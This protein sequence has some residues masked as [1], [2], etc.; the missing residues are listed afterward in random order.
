MFDLHHAQ[1]GEATSILCVS[2]SCIAIGKNHVF[3]ARMKHI[4]NHYHYVRI[5]L[6][7]IMWRISSLKACQL[8]FLLVTDMAW[9]YEI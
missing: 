1:H 7:R 5:V 4:E 6:L 8:H 3:N 2:V 9:G